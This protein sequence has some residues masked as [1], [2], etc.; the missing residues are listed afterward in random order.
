MG[1][2]SR[3]KN[4]P[5]LVVCALIAMECMLPAARS[6]AADEDALVSLWRQHMTAPED[7]AAI[8]LAC[9]SYASTHAGDPLVPVARGIEAWHKL[10]TGMLQEAFAIWE[11]DFA[12]PSTPLNDCARRLACGW[13]SRADREKVAGALQAHYRKEVAYPSELSQVGSHPKLNSDAKPPQTDRF[14]KPWVYSLTGITTASGFQDQKYSLRSA[15]LGPLSELRAAQ[16][17]AYGSKITAIPQRI[18]T[19][20]DS[21][22]AVSF[23]IGTSVSLSL[24]GPGTGDLHLAFIGLKCIVV[25]DHTHWKIFPRP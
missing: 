21:T 13:M 1:N 2:T 8:I 14:G 17:L 15:V 24:L 16:E 9:Q 7:H 18:T 6:P 25:C 10:R 4:S 3:F 5:L 19:M 20:P 12:L 11:S 22:L 23:K